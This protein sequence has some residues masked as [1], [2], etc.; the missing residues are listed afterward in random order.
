M[1]ASL[2]EVRR[3]YRQW[4]GLFVAHAAGFALY[5]AVDSAFWCWRW[6]L[7]GSLV[8]VQERWSFRCELQ[9]ISRLNSV[10]PVLSIRLMLRCHMFRARCLCMFSL[11]TWPAP[12]SIARTDRLTNQKT[13]SAFAGATLILPEGANIRKVGGADDSQHEEKKPLCA[14]SYPVDMVKYAEALLRSH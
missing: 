9:P 2:T 10:G 14:T 6:L 13:T 12:V 7:S 4:S 8:L 1:C 3:R 11:L 5:T